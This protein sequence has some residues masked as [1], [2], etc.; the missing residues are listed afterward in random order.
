M[1]TATYEVIV[2]D[3]SA[4]TIWEVI[5]KS[6][7]FVDKLNKEP[8][9][10]FTF[11]FEELKKMADTN[12]TT[13]I[14]IFTAALR[15]IYINRNGTKIFYGVVT[16]F[17]VTPGGQGDRTV[18]VKAMGF[19]GLF[20]KRLVGI[21]TETVYSA[22]DAGDIAWDLIDDSQ[23]SDTPYS[24]WGITQGAT[25]TTKDRDRSYLFDDIY[26]E[27]VR[28]SNENLADGFDFDIDTSKAFNVYYPTKGQSRP[29][30]VF[31]ERTMM[32]W[33][34]EK[35]LYS[36]MVNIVYAVGE[37]FNEDIISETRTAGTAFRSPFGTLEEKLDARNVTE[38]TTLQDKGDRRLDDAKEPI[39]SLEN[40]KHYDDDEAITYDDYNV[41]D[42][43][44]V[45]LPDFGVDSQSFR[46]MERRFNM[47]SNDSIGLC[48][49]VL[50]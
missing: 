31:D 45:N 42:T 48:T 20:K 29:T 21:G 17:V 47:Q 50:E 9:A 41:G 1:T 25:P 12:D 46:V 13:V 3:P 44:V 37:G 26:E 22:Q 39:E 27:I 4:G 32:S 23:N 34:Y 24:G 40:V 16:D 19:F 6:Y 14:N 2:K 18:S 49:V 5:P 43:V 30:V 8:T 28:L 7:S 11:S 35:S 15:E 38:A 36:G 10:D 33:R